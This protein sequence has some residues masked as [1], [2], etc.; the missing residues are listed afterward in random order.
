MRLADFIRVNL[1]S[2]MAE[3]EAFASTC[4]PAAEAMTLMALRDHAEEMLQ[5]I[6]A[7]MESSQSATEQIEKSRGEGRQHGN[8]LDQL[9][10]THGAGRAVVGFSLVQVA[11]EHRAL[12]ASVIRLWERSLPTAADLNITDLT[13]FN[14]AID[15]ILMESVTHYATEAERCRDRFIAILGHDLRSPIGAI[16]TAAGVMARSDQ[17]GNPEVK[18][19]SIIVNS[20]THISQMV[21]DLMEFARTRLGAAIPVLPSPMD[22]GELCRQLIEI[23]QGLH[24]DRTLQLEASGNLQGEW[25]SPRLKQVVSNLVGN[26]VQHGSRQSPVVVR[27]GGEAEEVVLT[28]HNE[29][30]PIPPEALKIIFEPLVRAGQEASEKRARSTSLGLGLYIAR[31]IVIAHGG[32]LS[33]A[34]SEPAGTTFTVRLP[35]RI[36][37]S[38]SI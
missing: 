33:V 10:E 22:L 29:G 14:E 38:K 8:P 36:R 31:M 35:R 3:W 9:G 32:T 2:I 28:V 26:A 34:S 16:L 15:Q 4:L 30:P 1:D 7:D 18:A 17:L 12:R 13:R 6:A 11:A 25:D 37:F 27:V 20:A 24:P 23:F 21:T 19:I 5:A